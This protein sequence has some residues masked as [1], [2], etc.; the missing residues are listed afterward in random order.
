MKVVLNLIPVVSGGGQQQAFSLLSFLENNYSESSD[1]LILVGEKSSLHEHLRQSRLKF[2]AFKT[3]Y[4]NRFI[5]DYFLVR[6]VVAS[7]DP[8]VIFHFTVAWNGVFVP[9]VVRTVYS[10]LYFP[11]VKFWKRKPILTYWKKLAI[12]RLRLAGTLRADGLIFENR[13]MMER[14]A[15]LLGFPSHRTRYI[16]PSRVAVI[17]NHEIDSVTEN[18]KS[19]FR[20]LYLSSWYKNKNIGILPFVA[21]CL[22][23]VDLDVRFLLTVDPMNP[24]VKESIVDKCEEL[25]VSEQFELI[26]TVHPAD[27]PSLIC[28]VDSMILL[29]ELECFSSNLVEAWSFGK[30]L[31]ISDRQWARSECAD[32]AIYVEPSSPDAIASSIVK[33][34][35]DV[36]AR[37]ELINRGYQV[38]ENFNTPESKAL[39]QIAFL[40]YICS[41][42]KK[43]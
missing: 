14:S 23:E 43:S 42:G 30:P 20:V 25:G 4:L 40:E 21:K 18:S 17:S 5:L 27:V 29:S 41:V 12:D 15:S 22:C 16:R 19:H 6:N 3:G 32:A 2:R 10:N 36:E 31:I 1:W 11:E 24:E 26:G 35:H 38:L 37:L 8:D 33:L 9:Q 13:A 7:F 34:V 28:S 39:E